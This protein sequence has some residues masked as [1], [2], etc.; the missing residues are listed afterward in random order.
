[1]N[2]CLQNRISE[3]GLVRC[4]CVRT[5]AIEI[6]AR[7]VKLRGMSPKQHHNKVIGSNQTPDSN[8]I[9]PSNKALVKMQ[10]PATSGVSVQCRNIFGKKRGHRGT[11]R[12][13][14][15]TRAEDPG[16]KPKYSGTIR[17]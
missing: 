8:R 12:E 11:K 15:S 17:A 5:A 1:V 16:K 3:A 7:R 10:E 2:R 6:A 14:E 4:G 13:H 9:L